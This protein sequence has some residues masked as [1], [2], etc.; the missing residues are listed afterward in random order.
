MCIRDRSI[1][2]LPDREKYI[3]TQRRLSENPPTLEDLGKQFGVSRERIRQLE[4]RAF[5]QVRESVVALAKKK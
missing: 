2:Q 4:A 1:A 5:K 3:F